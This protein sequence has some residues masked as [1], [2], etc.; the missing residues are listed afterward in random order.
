MNRQSNQGKQQSAATK[1]DFA[2]IDLTVDDTI[3]LYFADVAQACPNNNGGDE[4]N[5]DGNKYKTPYTV[6][7]Y[8]GKIDE[9]LDGPR[10]QDVRGVPPGE[11]TYSGGRRIW[12]LGAWHD[13]WEHWTTMVL[14]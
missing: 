4:G 9:Y 10:F 8:I 1:K 6:D 7:E 13:R 14:R 2:V 3:L 5:N 11:R 12:Q